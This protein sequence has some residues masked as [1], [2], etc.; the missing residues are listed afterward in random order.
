M[1][2]KRVSAALFLVV[3]FGFSAVLL[4]LSLLASVKLAALDDTAARLEKEQQTLYNE[5]RALAAKYEQS[6]SLDEVER[7]AVEE[8]GMCRP[9]AEQIEYITMD[10]GD[11]D[12]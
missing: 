1:T 7:I 4:V 5:N 12:K 10:T 11:M 9:S 6:I 2:M 3:I 8:L